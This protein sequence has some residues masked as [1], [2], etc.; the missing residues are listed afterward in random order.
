M[1]LVGYSRFMFNAWQNATR[2][3]EEASKQRGLLGGTDCTP[4]ERWS[5]ALYSLKPDVELAVELMAWGYFKRDDAQEGLC[6]RAWHLQQKTEGELMDAKAR[7]RLLMAGGALPEPRGY[8]QRS[9]QKS[10]EDKSA[11]ERFS[12]ATMAEGNWRHRTSG[13][14][15]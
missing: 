2:L 9:Q 5:K 3:P 8:V 10:E 13:P 15:K 7:E 11:R 1:T 14:D 12:T 4:T 6:Q